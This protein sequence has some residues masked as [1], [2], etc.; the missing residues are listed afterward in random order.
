MNQQPQTRQ[1]SSPQSARAG[2]CLCFKTCLSRIVTYMHHAG[3]L[4]AGQPNS[5]WSL[6]STLHHASV[7]S[8]SPCSVFVL[9]TMRIHAVVQCSL[10]IMCREFL[11]KTA[12]RSR[13]ADP[14]FRHR[15]TG[16]CIAFVSICRRITQ[17]LIPMQQVAE[18]SCSPRS[19]AS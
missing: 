14:K 2:H 7:I 4:C 17:F 11:L 3:N 15:K 6:C 16:P 8:M 18:S 9:S 5:F 1:S 10:Q 19:H 13:H 12:D